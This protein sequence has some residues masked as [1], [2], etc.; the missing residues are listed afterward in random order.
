MLRMLFNPATL[1]LLI[2]I[3]AIVGHFVVK[4]QQMQYD[5]EE[6]LEKIRAGIDPDA[7]E[8]ETV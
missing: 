6:R 5:H 3:A 4:A 1:A 2:P 8:R 7:H